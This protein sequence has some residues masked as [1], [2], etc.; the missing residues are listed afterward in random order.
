MVVRRAVS[1]WPLWKLSRRLQ[2]LVVGVVAAYCAAIAAAAAVTRVQAGQMRLFALLLACG[3]IAVEVTRRVGEP[4]GVVR[5][6]YALWDLPAAV[7]LPPMYALL[8]PIPRM[9]LT[10]ARIRRGVVHR[11]AYTAAAVGLAYAAASVVFHT[12]AQGLGTGAG[13]G[14]GGRA[15][16]WTLLAAG[17]GLIRLAVNDTLVLTAVK[18]SAPET[19]LMREIFGPEAVHGNIAELALGTLTAFGT[20]HSALTVLYAV[21]LVTSLQRSLRHAQL[22]SETRVDSKTGLLNDKTWRREAASEITRAVRTRAPLAVGLIDIDHFKRVNDTFGH[23]TGDA[24]LAA[25]AAATKALLREY[26][27]VGRVGGEEFAF[28]LPHTPLDVACEIAERLRQK[29]PLIAVPRQ[30]PAEPPYPQVT[31]SIGI[32]A[33]ERP[34]WDLSRYFGLADQALYT[35]KES[36]RDRVS[37]ITG[38]HE[39]ARPVVSRA[40][41]LPR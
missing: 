27:I 9:V 20:A 11:R 23:L 33:A 37:V 41:I 40:R 26:D 38:E 32:A 3:A 6:V 19:P 7:L 31:V 14:M 16:L 17:C 12:A 22:V 8:A 25:V 2:V 24:V 28:L 13:A 5:D 29:I 34:R 15:M 10:Q 21:P 18:A 4:T 1:G 30:G 39:E 35:A 36:G